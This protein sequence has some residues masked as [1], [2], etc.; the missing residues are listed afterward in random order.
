M[1]GHIVS[2]TSADEV[3]HEIKLIYYFHEKQGT[4]PGIIR[5][6]FMLWG[7]LKLI[8]KHRSGLFVLQ[9]ILNPTYLS[10]FNKIPP[11]LIS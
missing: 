7:C 10:L 11:C 9:G 2:R 3:L 8:W 6:F 1:R 5:V 4:T